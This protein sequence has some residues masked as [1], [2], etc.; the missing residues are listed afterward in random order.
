MPHL[1]KR[2]ER[3]AKD[4]YLMELFAPE[5][6]RNYQPGQFIVLRVDE[7]GERIPLTVTSTGKETIE[8]IFQV[9]GKS[10]RKLAALEAGSKVL[11]CVGPLGRP[12]EIAR[13]GRVLC[14]GGGT[15]IGC[16]APLVRALSSAG[17]DVTSV[18][19]ARSAS[20][21]M[22]EDELGRSSTQLLVAT[23]DGSKGHR[24]FVTDILRK[25]LSQAGFDRVIAIGPATMMKAVAEQTR[26]YKIPTFAS[27]NTIMVDATGMCG[28]CRVFVDG[29]MKLTCTDGPMFD[30]HGLNFDDIISRS[31]MFREK[32]LHEN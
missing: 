5:V 13:F 7:R 8:L 23:D 11:D 1:I 10:T 4:H 25:L 9:V 22:L 2:K 24:G 21:L 16:I 27:L 30:A 19:G 12:A 26:A 28:S 29:K 17:N 6:A 15:G 20:M 18:I 32:E 3:L 14:V 31:A